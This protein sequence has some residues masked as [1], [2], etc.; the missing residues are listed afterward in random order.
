MEQLKRLFPFVLVIFAFALHA[1]NLD[2]TSYDLD[3]AVHIWHAQKSYSDVVDQSA[4]DPNPP[5]YNLI[6]STWVK[7][8]GVSEWTT[9]FFSVLMSVLAVL[10]VYLIGKRNFG[11]AVGI[12]AALLFCFSPIQF[13]FSHLARPYS[14]LMVS[15]IMSYG[16]L[17][18]AIRHPSRKWYVLYFLSTSWMIYVHPTSVFNL[19]AQG[20]MAILMLFS[21]RRNLIMLIA[22]QVAAAGSFA[23][24]V[25]SVPYFERDDKMWFA[26]PDMNA[27]TQVLEVFHGTMWIFVVSMLLL[28]IVALR[29]IFLF[30]QDDDR[31]RKLLLLVLWILVPMLGSIAVSHAF[32]PVFQDKYILSVQ[33]AFML[34]LAYSIRELFGERTRFIPLIPVFF[35][36]GASTHL[37]P[38]TEG[39]WRNAV[40]HISDVKTENT[41]VFIHPWYEFRTFAFYYDRAGYE[42][43]EVTQ[44]R[45]VE[46][47][48]YT[49]WHDLMPGGVA[50]ERTDEIILLTAHG[51]HVELPFPL[52]SLM[53]VAE[54]KDERKYSGIVLRHF[55]LKAKE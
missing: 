4:N 38:W 33:P 1:H 35:G 31:G 8:F 39:D 54:L 32:K 49:A 50:H 41:S 42:Q 12:M 30:G 6:L 47:H 18:E 46:R 13:R 23:I 27:V 9:R 24:W 51:N 10:A 16:L 28:A 20:L 29:I 52:D 34:M 3:E 5:V 40:G 22:T 7:F 15:V 44:K 11:L 21:S 55:K 37:T 53:Q 17:F 48:I 19:P 43:P 36:L 45:L 2:H 26:A 14:L 25:F